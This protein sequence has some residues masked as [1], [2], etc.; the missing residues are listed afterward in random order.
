LAKTTVKT[1]KDNFPMM[2][3]SLKALNGRKV[4]VGH[5]GGGEQAWLAGIHEYGLD[6]EITPKMRV[7]LHAN[8][9]HVKDST[10]HIHIP[11]RSFL[12][13]GFDEN[14]EKVIEKCRNALKESLDS[15]NAEI[16]LE[17]VGLLLRDAI[18]DYANEL[19]DPP[20]HPFS[21]EMNPGKTNPLIISGDMIEAL[22]YEVE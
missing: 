12:R 18:V 15:G 11:E 16:Y 1:T 19:K 20:K 10:T 5:L 7:W 9:L 17:A 8:G 22:T 13:S 4:N 6:I 21:L 14:H 2:E 3:Q